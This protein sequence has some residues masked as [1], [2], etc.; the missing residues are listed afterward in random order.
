MFLTSTSF[1]Q[2][3]CNQLFAIKLR[4]L[5]LRNYSSCEGRASS[6][7]TCALSSLILL[8]SSRETLTDASEIRVC[9]CWN[10]VNM[11]P[12]DCSHIPQKYLIFQKYFTS[13]KIYFIFIYFKKI[14]FLPSKIYLLHLQ[15]DWREQGVLLQNEGRLPQILGRVRHG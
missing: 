15:H 3:N 9:I 12:P 13:Y 7:L 10:L 4:P 14:F 2:G 8:Q 1:H 6:K 5:F 11:R